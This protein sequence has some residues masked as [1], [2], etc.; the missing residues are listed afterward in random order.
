MYKPT[1][2]SIVSIL[3]LLVLLGI[4]LLVTLA[5]GQP[6]KRAC[7]WKPWW[8]EKLGD[9]W[10][11]WMD[12]CADEREKEMMVAAFTKLEESM[13]D[14]SYLDISAFLED[15]GGAIGSYGDFPASGSRR[16][17]G[18]VKKWDRSGCLHYCPVELY[19]L[20]NEDGSYEVYND[21]PKRILE[22]F[23]YEEGMDYKTY[24][25]DGVSLAYDYEAAMLPIFIVYAD[26]EDGDFWE[27]FTHVCEN[28]K[29]WQEEQGGCLNQTVKIGETSGESLE[30]LM[31][32]YGDIELDFAKLADSEEELTRL[33]SVVSNELT[34]YRGRIEPAQE[35]HTSKE[36]GS[37][38]Y[39]CEPGD[40]L[41]K[42]AETYLKST[43]MIPALCDDPHNQIADADL[44]FIGQRIYIPENLIRQQDMCKTLER[45]RTN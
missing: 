30:T 2:K 5:E 20:A 12:E 35:D 33:K 16:I 32:Y 6:G 14:G 34:A 28:V 44:I 19:I 37:F 45:Y 36:N 1:K 21:Y 9:A 18:R 7:R 27:S 41:W 24:H 29:E 25:G 38:W 8:D 40:T 31:E 11:Q 26:E 42:I 43:D 4:S 39:I 23:L 13:I 3:L 22:G 15:A 10:N 17:D